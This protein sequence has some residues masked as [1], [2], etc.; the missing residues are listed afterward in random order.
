MNTIL[1]HDVIQQ[2]NLCTK[3]IH[4]KSLTANQLKI[5]VQRDKSILNKIMVHSSPLRS[6]NGFWHKTFSELKNMVKQ[7]GKPTIFFTLSVADYHWLDLFRLL[8]PNVPYENIT[9]KE[10]RQLMHDNPIIVSFFLQERV[11]LFIKHVIKPVFKV[12]DMWYRFEWQNRGIPH[13]HGVLW[14]SDEPNVDVYAITDEQIEQ[15]RFC[16]DNICSAMNPSLCSEAVTPHPSQLRFTDVNSSN[17]TRD[18][19]NF[20]NT[21]Q[22]HTKCGTHCL[23]KINGKLSCRFNFRHTK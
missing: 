4:E 9:E 14:L 23:R 22:R 17:Y 19:S 6:T 13:I 12:K 2:S 21:F 1:S 8:R 5:M 16:F 7:L 18:L 15:I 3:L 11:R 10:K 20:I